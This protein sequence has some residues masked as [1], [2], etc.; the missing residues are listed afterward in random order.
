[1]GENLPELLPL[2]LMD[3]AAVRY[4]DSGLRDDVQAIGLWRIH[5]YDT[6]GEPYWNADQITAYARA[7]MAELE[8]ANEQLHAHG[9]S[10]YAQ[11]DALTKERDAMRED[12]EE[13][14]R[15]VNRASGQV[16]RAE[17]ELAKAREDARRYR[18]LREQSGDNLYVCG[19]HGEQFAGMGW[20]IGELLDTQIDAALAHGQGTDTAISGEGA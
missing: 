10:M 17:A 5:M 7:N 8:R 14:H 3:I 9:V 11:I 19:V 15:A 20:L 2:P 18:W 16:T 1:M 12:V 4:P 6:G 13:M